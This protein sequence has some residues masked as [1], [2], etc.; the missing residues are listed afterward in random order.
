[1]VIAGLARSTRGRIDELLHHHREAVSALVIFGA[2][3]VG[4]GFVAPRMALFRLVVGDLE[5]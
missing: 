2:P 4:Q 1:M 3:D 5:V